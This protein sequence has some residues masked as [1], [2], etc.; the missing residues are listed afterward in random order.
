MKYNKQLLFSVITPKIIII[1]IEMHAVDLWII[2]I[3]LLLFLGCKILEKY[4][5]KEEDDDDD[6]ALF[7]LIIFIIIWN[8]MD[9]TQTKRKRKRKSQKGR[10]EALT[11]FCCSFISCDTMNEIQNNNFNYK[12]KKSMKLASISFFHDQFLKSSCNPFDNDIYY[13]L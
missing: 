5:N 9:K 1:I 13:L 11:W 4:N 10:L 12:N 6:G 8:K 3:L 7:L 2:Y